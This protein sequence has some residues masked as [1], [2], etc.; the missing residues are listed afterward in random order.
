M[1]DISKINVGG[2]PYGIAGTSLIA[3]VETSNVASQQ[4]LTGDQFV[5]NGLLYKATTTIAQGGTITVGSNCQL[6]DIVTKQINEINS[7]LTAHTFGTVV[8]ITSY[9]S[10][11]NLYTFPSDGY[12]KMYANTGDNVNVKFYAGGTIMENQVGDST[13]IN[14][15]SVYVKKGMQCYCTVSTSSSDV[16]FYP[17]T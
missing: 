16:K 8:N 13:K 15:V 4:Y 10:A 11:S 17:L 7:S 3:P 1:P 5:Y 12:V 14:V 2:T 9:N 6:A